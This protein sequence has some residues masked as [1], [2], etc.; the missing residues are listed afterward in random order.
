MKFRSEFGRMAKEVGCPQQS[1]PKDK[2]QKSC[3]GVTQAR[4]CQLVVMQCNLSTARL[5][6]TSAL[7]D[8]DWDIQS[9][10]PG[11]DADSACK[12]NH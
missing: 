1:G 7:P 3:C 6:S 4:R 11:K 12:V 9:Y 8:W 10:A 2:T 5:L